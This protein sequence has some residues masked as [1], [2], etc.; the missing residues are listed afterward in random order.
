[1]SVDFC[2]KLFEGLE[3]DSAYDIEGACQFIVLK[4]TL[5]AANVHQKVALRI[6]GSF[7][8]LY[9]IATRHFNLLYFKVK[10]FDQ[11]AVCR[12]STYILSSNLD[13]DQGISRP[14]D[15]NLNVLSLTM[16]ISYLKGFLLYLSLRLYT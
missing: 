15:T 6:S 11:I 12:E 9:F 13:P 16:G 14:F 2:T 7:V 3:S 5:G 1:M 4:A 10:P 8:C